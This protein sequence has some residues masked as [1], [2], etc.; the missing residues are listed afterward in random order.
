MR[1]FPGPRPVR[2]IGRRRIH[3][4]VHP[5]VPGRADLRRLGIVAVDHPAALEAKRRIDLAALG[6]VI[7]VAELVLADEL[8]IE[9]GP[10]LRAEGLAVPPREAAQKECLD[11]HG[12]LV[13]GRCALMTVHCRAVQQTPARL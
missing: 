6:A 4:V 11:F 5:A 8:A 2:L 9:R 12:W 10:H 3:G 1:L 13:A 7:A